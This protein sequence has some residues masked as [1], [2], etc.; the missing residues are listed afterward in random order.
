MRLKTINENMQ[1]CSFRD[2][3]GFLFRQDGEL[4][5]FISNSYGENFEYLM[6]SGLWDCL[7]N[8]NLIINNTEV[9]IDV[10]FADAENKYKIYKPDMIPF[11]S[12][13]YE[14]CFSALKQAALLS[15]KIQRISLEHNMTLKDASAYNIQFIG[16]KPIF[17]DILSFEKYKEGTPWIAYKQFCRHFAAP[18]LLMS[19]KEPELQSLLLSNID[20]IPLPLAAK[21]LPKRTLLNFSIFTHIHLNAFMQKLC[22][23]ETSKKTKNIMLS[24]NSQINLLI[25]LE[26]LINNLKFKNTET[27]WS[28]Y[29]DI[30]N[31]DEDSFEHKKQ[32]VKEYLSNSDSETVADIGANTGMFS[33]IAEKA[34]K[35]VISCDMDYLAVENNYIRLQKEADDKILP[36][37]IDLCTPSPS[38]GW[39]CRERQ[40]FFER[41]G[42]DKTVLALALIHHLRISNNVPVK[43]LA[44][45]FSGISKNLIIEFVPKEDSMVQKLLSTRED[46]FD[47]YSKPAFEKEFS[48]YFNIINSSQISNSDRF[49]YL[50]KRK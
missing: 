30:K 11:I 22:S 32:L 4:Y 24:K 33:E 16:T 37:I 31:Y 2:P 44:E 35:Y 47:D 48:N 12:Y 29:Y 9:D 17:I 21:L 43:K 23:E 8:Q 20:G 7:L 15:L 26:S 38:V 41:I 40:S 28:N 27:V 10:N 49:L 45:F 42:N 46:I 14:W 19:Y 1:D 18:L 25:D 5:R 39:F 36:L 34:D 13:P 50:M 6:K 3:S